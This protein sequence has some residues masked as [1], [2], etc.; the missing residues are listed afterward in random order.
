MKLGTKGLSIKMN[1][2]STSN[3]DIIFLRKRTHDSRSERPLWN[4]YLCK[5]IIFKLQFDLSPGRLFGLKYCL[6]S[7]L[8]YT[9]YK[10]LGM[11]YP[12]ILFTL[13][14]MQGIGCL[15]PKSINK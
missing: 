12:F 11:F 1:L 2:F 7:R 9:L 15:F 4:D 5:N 8:K 3:L 14:D 10:I 6:M 13:L